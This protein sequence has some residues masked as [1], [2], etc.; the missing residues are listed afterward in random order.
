MDEARKAFMKYGDA[1]LSG[2]DLALWKNDKGL[3]M[4]LPQWQSVTGYEKHSI[5]GNINVQ[6]D[7]KTF[8]L[9]VTMDKSIQQL[10]C[11]PV[12]T[13]EVRD[14]KKYARH[15]DKDFIAEA[16]PS[17]RWQAGAF[18]NFRP[19]RNQFTIWP[20]KFEYPAMPPKVAMEPQ[21]GSEG[22]KPVPKPADNGSK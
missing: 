13:V 6:M 10:N 1:N 17:G 21:A 15:L 8:E 9:T 7:L 14:F 16:L 19:G 20:V 4:N 2:A 22:L 5:T 11:P 3:A 18:Q 12:K